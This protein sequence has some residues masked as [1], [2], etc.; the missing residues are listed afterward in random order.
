MSGTPPHSPNAAARQNAEPPTTPVLQRVYDNPG[1]DA[2]SV[3]PAY[4]AGLHDFSPVTDF[5]GDNI[6][7][8][9]SPERVSTTSAISLKSPFFQIVLSLLTNREAR[10]GHAARAFLFFPHYNATHDNAI[11]R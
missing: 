4:H 8:A 9:A 5:Q 10:R 1:Y 2:P 11:Y 7:P 3:D 6:T